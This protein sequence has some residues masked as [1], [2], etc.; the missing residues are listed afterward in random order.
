MNLLTA[1]VFTLSSLYLLLLLFIFILQIKLIKNK[2][3]KSQIELPLVSILVAARNEENN[4]LNCLKSLNELTYPKN[5]IEI[6]IGNDDSQDNTAKIITEYIQDKNQFKL[7]N[8]SAHNTSK[9]KGKARVLSLLIQNAKSQYYLITDADITVNPMWVNE[10]MH[11]LIQ[12]NHG[13]VAGTTMI[14]S[15]T[16]FGHLQRLDWLYFKGIIKLFSELRN[17]L[18]AVGNNMCISKKAY[19]EVGG[20]ENIPF[21]ITE[22]YALFKAIRDK[23]FS[24]SQLFNSESIVYSAP[25]DKFKTLMNQRKRWLVG[26]LDLPLKYKALIFLFGFWYF[27]IPYLAITHHFFELFCFI[28]CKT[29]I[30]LFQFLFLHKQLN[31]KVNS[32]LALL[33]YDLYLLVMI[34]LSSLYFF[35]PTKTIWK[36]RKY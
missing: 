7:F 28:L 32:I 19:D 3:L 34:P 24:T 9:T 33:T 5:N 20:Y 23:G 6:L 11:E 17:P 8:F 4:I 31:K 16:Y 14:Q 36:G 10:M 27:A 25:V 15:N 26:G 2:Q 18:T 29:S 12:N 21:S 22:D 35:I 1:I 30:Q 13:L